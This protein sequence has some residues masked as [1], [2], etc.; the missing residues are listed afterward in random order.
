ML[1]FPSSFLCLFFNF[2]QGMIDFQ[3]SK[4]LMKEDD[5]NREKRRAFAEKQK[6][7]KDAE[8]KTKKKNLE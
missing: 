2:Y 8:K 5:V 7:T 1:F 6:S 3:S 4:P